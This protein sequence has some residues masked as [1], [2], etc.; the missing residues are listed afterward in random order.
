[1]L[2]KRRT[3]VF[4]RSPTI[5]FV[6][7]HSREQKIWRQKT[8]LPKILE[9]FTNVIRLLGLKGL[10]TPLHEE[11]NYVYFYVLNVTALLRQICHSYIL[12]IEIC[13]PVNLIDITKQQFTVKTWNFTKNEPCQNMEI[14]TGFSTDLMMI[15]YKDLR[16]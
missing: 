7:W 13:M 2:T 15:T 5:A 14:R 9:L 6:V 1:M 12:H 3:R 8:Y 16:I 4:D 10:A 11:V